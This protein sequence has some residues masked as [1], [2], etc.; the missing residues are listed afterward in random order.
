MLQFSLTK[1]ILIWVVVVLGFLFAM[2]NGFYN[3]VESVNDARMQLENGNDTPEII[4]PSIKLAIF[5]TKCFGQFRSRF[6]WWS[7]PTCK[8]AR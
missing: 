7:T 8:S 5:L 1:K 6:T 2:P 3:R 4:I